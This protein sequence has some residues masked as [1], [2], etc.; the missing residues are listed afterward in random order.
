M[1]PVGCCFLWGP[2]V[3]CYGTLGLLFVMGPLGCVCYGTLGLFV[4]QAIFAC[5]YLY[6]ILTNVI[7]YMTFIA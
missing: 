5:S 1:G 4:M 3:V 7:D 6:I 2:W